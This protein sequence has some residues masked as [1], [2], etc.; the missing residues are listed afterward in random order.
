[1]NK[2]QVKY[3]NLL[4]EYSNEV[5]EANYPYS[6]KSGQYPDKHPFEDAPAEILDDE[7]LMLE[8]FEYDY[9]ECFKFCSYRLRNKKDFVMEALRYAG[10]E[11]DQIGENLKN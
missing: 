4:Q 2:L 9:A 7:E 11:Y 10:P 1:M 3:L 8:C 6:E 5:S